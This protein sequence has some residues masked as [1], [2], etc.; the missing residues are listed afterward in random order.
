MDRGVPRRAL[1]LEEAFRVGQPL[2]MCPALL[3]IC[4]QQIVCSEVAPAQEGR[5]E[6]I[7]RA[8]ETT[9]ANITAE[10]AA[11]WSAHWMASGW[12]VLDHRCDVKRMVNV[13]VHVLR[14]LHV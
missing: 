4:D 2:C 5:A 11:T 10:E 13:D 12:R 14:G 7:R 8:R 9:A 1:L 6:L 3:R